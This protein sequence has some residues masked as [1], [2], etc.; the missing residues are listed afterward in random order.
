MNSKF[1]NV[2]E[3]YRGL[4]T[5][6]GNSMQDRYGIWVDRYTGA[7]LSRSECKSREL[8]PVKHSQ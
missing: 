7:V 4:P 8:R 1:Y 5:C 6:K 3:E 2:S